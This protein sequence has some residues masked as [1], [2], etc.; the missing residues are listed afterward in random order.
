MV[1]GSCEFCENLFSERH[2]LFCGIND[3]PFTVLY[4]YYP[5]WIKFGA[6]DLHAMLLSVSEFCENWKTGCTSVG[7]NEIPF[8][9]VL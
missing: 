2:T 8:M 1:L 7:I 6:T 9:H 5:I 3:F 4:I